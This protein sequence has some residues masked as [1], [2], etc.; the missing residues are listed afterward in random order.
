[1]FFAGGLFLKSPARITTCPLMGNSLLDYALAERELWQ[2]LKAQNETIPKVKGKPTKT[3]T[4]RRVAQMFEEID[5]LL[6]R[7]SEQVLLIFSLR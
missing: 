5:V 2:L 3:P 7:F 4:M 6:I 1:M